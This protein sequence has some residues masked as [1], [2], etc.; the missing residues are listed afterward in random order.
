MECRAA[1]PGIILCTPL[2]PLTPEATAYHRLTDGVGTS[3]LFGAISIGGVV[4]FIKNILHTFS[5]Y[6]S[7]RTL[8]RVL[9]THTVSG[10]GGGVP[11]P[12]TATSNQA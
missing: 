6:F 9:P 7:E 5:M 12:D 11:P 10:P 2:A 4:V 8:V 3:T 1:D